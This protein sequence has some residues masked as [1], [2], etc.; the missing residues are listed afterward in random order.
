[1]KSLE[2]ADG[3][4]EI[5]ATVV[6]KGLGIA[7]TLLLERLREGK[8]TSRCERGIDVDSGRYRLTFYS[9]NRRFRLVVDESGAILQR[10]AIDFGDQPLPTSARRLGT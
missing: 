10:S 7:P 4:I 2:F 8:I 1:M 3:A 6:A 5:D 9:V